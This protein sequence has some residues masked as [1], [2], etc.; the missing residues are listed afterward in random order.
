MFSENGY[1]L[2]GDR[3]LSG[4]KMNISGFK[5]V[6]LLNPHADD[7]EISSGGTIVNLIRSGSKVYYISFSMPGHPEEGKFREK[8]VLKEIRNATIKLGIKKENLILLDFPIRRFNEKRQEILDELIRLKKKFRPDLVFC[9]SSFDVHQDHRVIHEEALR[10]F[11]D[12]SILGYE[13]HWNQVLGQDNRIFVPISE[14]VFKI[15]IE[16]LKEYN[17]QE[18]RGYFLEKMHRSIMTYHGF[19][20]KQKYAECFECIRLIL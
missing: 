3:Q 14:E 10:A 16:A 8:E 18:S 11:K 13:S 12:C 7:S 6:F 15:K 5:I 1:E 9:H 17:T 19:Q 4:G 20:I 2:F